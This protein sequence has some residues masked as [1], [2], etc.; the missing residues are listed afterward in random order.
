MGFGI[1]LRVRGD[2]ACF[3]RPEMKAERVSYD[4]VTPSAARGILEAIFW[5]PAI[6]WRIDR[7][8]VLNPI[9]FDSVRRNEVSSKISTRNVMQAMRGGE[10]ALGLDASDGRERVQR[11]SY[12]LRDVDY[13][14]EAHFD[15]TD[16]AGPGDTKEKHFNMALRRMRKGQCFH[17]PYLGCREFPLRFELVEGEIPPSCYTGET[18][19]LGFMLHDIDFADDKTPVFYR[20]VMR[21]G[22]IDCSECLQAGAAA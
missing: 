19:D 13:V 10:V 12:L 20:A 11:A 5:K 3:T 8:H 21:D 1:A 18:V 16:R 17:Q 14:I 4:V 15:L 6:A 2:Y 9:R 7:L 22:V